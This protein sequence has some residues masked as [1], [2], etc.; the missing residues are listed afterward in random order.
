MATTARL[1]SSF[2]RIFHKTSKARIKRSHCDMVCPCLFI[3][4]FSLAFTS[5]SARSATSAAT[6][7]LA[8]AR[9][10]ARSSATLSQP[11]MLLNSAL[12]TDALVCP[13]HQW[14]Y[15]T[16][17]LDCKCL[18]VVI[19]SIVQL[20]SPRP[21]NEINSNERDPRFLRQQG[22]PFSSAPLVKTASG[23]TTVAGATS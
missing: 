5:R 11:N 22:A 16:H 4:R 17:P 3:V 7:P 20:Q 14:T 1:G 23:L 18:D 19:P 6:M 10:K 2:A 13:Y 8:C 12:Q 21:F 15:A 9:G